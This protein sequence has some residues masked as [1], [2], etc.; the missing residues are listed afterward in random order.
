MVLY[1]QQQQQLQQYRGY[2]STNSGSGLGI[3]LSPMSPTSP[4]SSLS[5]TTIEPQQQQQQRHPP[6]KFDRRATTI[7]RMLEECQRYKVCKYQDRY[8]GY[9]KATKFHSYRAEERY[10]Q[11]RMVVLEEVRYM[12]ETRGMNEGR[13]AEEVAI[14]WLE[15]EFLKMDGSTIRFLEILKERQKLRKSQTEEEE[16]FGPYWNHNEWRPPHQTHY[17]E[18]VEIIEYFQAKERQERENQR[19][20]VLII[21]KNKRIR[22]RKKIKSNIDAPTP[23]SSPESPVTDAYLPTLDIIDLS[24]SSS[25]MGSP[26]S[27]TSFLSDSSNSYAPSPTP[28]SSISNPNPSATNPDKIYS[29]HYSSNRSDYIEDEVNQD[30][31]SSESE[32]N[33]RVI[34]GGL[35]MAESVNQ[36][37]REW[38]LAVDDRFDDDFAAR[39]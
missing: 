14:E 8:L 24:A 10:I 21:Q 36:W 12:M 17:E 39:D 34:S 28:D 31:S 26:T 6:F 33:S 1:Q 35:G 13:E 3:P 9:D 30:G 23:K 25:E 27:D 16:I 22:P 4:L 11:A 18:V 19:Q 5:A 7:R 20:E 32:E 15:K 29:T 37:S 2:I 38:I